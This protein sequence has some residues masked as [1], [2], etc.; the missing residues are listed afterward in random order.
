[1]VAAVLDELVKASQPLVRFLGFAR[2]GGKATI[3]GSRLFR[4]PSSQ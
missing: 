1:M 3:D 4:A 2:Q